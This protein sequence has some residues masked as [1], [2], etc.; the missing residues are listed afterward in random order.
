MW[1]RRAAGIVVVASALAA[2]GVVARDRLA[3]D[4]PPPSPWGPV[5]VAATAGAVETASGQVLP[6]VAA[7]PDGSFD[8]RTPCDA[9]GVVGGQVLTGAHVVL[10]PGHGGEEP[11]AVG[12]N[13]LLESNLNLDVAQ[14]VADI[15]RE[16]GATVVL[17]RVADVRVT[18]ATRAALAVAL[19]PE[20]F[21]SIHHNAAPEGPSTI[22]GTEA[23]FQVASPESRRLT[24][25][26]VEE[27]RAALTPFAVAWSSDADNGAKARVRAADP[28][29]DYY[30]VLRRSAG[31]PAALVEAAYLS[32]PP[33]AELL[34][35]PDVV[36][37]E[38][39]AIARALL[40]FHL[41]EVAGEAAF[42][43]APPSTGGS[44]SSGGTSDG[45]VDPPL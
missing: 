19:A 41:G 7:R 21:V 18:V 31:V 14:R 6:V 44:G 13:G 32:N 3:D 4:P 5:P 16:Q 9:I 37:A 29:E 43:T 39:E 40:R 34:A 8:V 38:A 2:I 27:V 23:Y 45:C 20:A 30:G 25:L 22:P 33:E 24:G 15:L 10:D 11:G 28:A 17:T 1:W 35:R 26:L 42:S 12:A 36:Q